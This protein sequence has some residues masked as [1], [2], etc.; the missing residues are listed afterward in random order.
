VAPR[1]N[2]GDTLKRW[3]TE[4]ELTL[5]QLAA[6]S[7]VSRAAI[8]KIERGDSAASTS[9]LGRLA[10]ALD[11]SISQLVGGARSE[12]VMHIPRER[13]PTFIEDGTGFERRSLSPMYSGRGIDFV[14]NRLPPKAKTGPFPSHREGVEEHLYVTKG[15]L[16]VTLGDTPHVIEAGDFLFYRGD[17]SHSFENLGTT[18]CEYLIVIDSTRLR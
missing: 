16:K 11:V 3:R 9:T 14:L 10:E 1:S 5:D 4:R 2:L 6:K 18:V 15:H 7:G 17:L 12:P 13:Q 8:S